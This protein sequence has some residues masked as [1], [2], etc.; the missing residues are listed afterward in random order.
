MSAGPRT[1]PSR[2]W[3]KKGPD[4]PAQVFAELAK[5][6]LT[7]MDSCREIWT[8]SADP[9]AL[10]AAVTLAEVPEWLRDALLVLL[11]DGAADAGLQRLLWKVRKR[12]ERD[13]AR[14]AEV[15]GLRC[16]PQVLVPWDLALRMADLFVR[17]HHSDE[18]SVSPEAIKQSWQRVSRG[19]ADPA[20]YYFVPDVAQRVSASGARVLAL[21]EAVI[22]RSPKILQ[23]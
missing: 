22:K 18:P 1:R 5:R 2:P 11:A 4:K 23:E 17:D 8:N 9:L 10:C 16:H 21:L 15:A 20:R 12:D 14:A 7:D 3:R 19:I 13:A 6:Q